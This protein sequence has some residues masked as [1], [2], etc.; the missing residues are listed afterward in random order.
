MWKY[1]LLFFARPHNN[2]QYINIKNTSQDDFVKMTVFSPQL[3]RTLW[4][5]ME[6]FDPFNVLVWKAGRAASNPPWAIM[7]GLEQGR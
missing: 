6:S 4:F 2:N 3:H 7:K 1:Y 5:K